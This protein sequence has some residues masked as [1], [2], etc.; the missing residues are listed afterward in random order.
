MKNF[1]AEEIHSNDRTEEV[2]A[3]EEVL[4]LSLDEMSYVAGG[5]LKLGWKY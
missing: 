3:H 2:E 1:T 4:E 5:Y